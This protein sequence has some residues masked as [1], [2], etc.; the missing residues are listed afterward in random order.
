MFTSRSGGFLRV[1]W[2]MRLRPPSACTSRESPGLER[3]VL[4]RRVNLEDAFFPPPLRNTAILYY[5]RAAEVR[6][7][8]Q[9]CI[10]LL[11][12]VILTLCV[13]QST[14]GQTYS[15]TYSV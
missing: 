1:A 15:C 2:V 3:P 4:S 5:W 6:M 14:F 9:A 11:T 10:R 13:P 7:Q 8:I 12:A